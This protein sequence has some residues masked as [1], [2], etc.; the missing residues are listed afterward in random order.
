IAKRYEGGIG[1]NALFSLQPGTTIAMELP[2]GGMWLSEKCSAAVLVAG[3]TGI[4]PI[5]AMVR[6]MVLAEDPRPVRVYYGAQSPEELAAWEELVLLVNSL[7]DGALIGVVEKSA[8]GWVG[9]SGFVT[10]ALRGC[11]ELS[12]STTE[13][14]LA[15]PPPMVDA[16]LA[17]LTEREVGLDRIRYDRF[18]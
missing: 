12:E 11:V 5:L 3:G 10:D 9:Q 8:E 14:Y 7:A 18:G 6:R 13:V 4:S 1:S 16:V 2:Y 17:V 15:G